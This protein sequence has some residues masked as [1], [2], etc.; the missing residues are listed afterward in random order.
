MHHVLQKC[1]QIDELERNLCLFKNKASIERSSSITAGQY[2]YT[3]TSLHY[4]AS[5]SATASSTLMH[6]DAKMRAIRLGQLLST[7]LLNRV[8]QFMGNE[9]LMLVLTKK[10]ITT[11]KSRKCMEESIDYGKRIEGK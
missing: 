5:R 4:I 10:N 11:K 9:K 7:I 6:T 8:I 3:R 1:K 2:N